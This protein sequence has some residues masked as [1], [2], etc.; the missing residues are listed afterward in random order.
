M[1]EEDAQ[2]DQMYVKTSNVSLY[3]ANCM[4]EMKSIKKKEFMCL[5]CGQKYIEKE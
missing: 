5:E 2:S 3:C 1:V 4:S